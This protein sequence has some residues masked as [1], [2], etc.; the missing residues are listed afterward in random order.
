MSSGESTAWLT[1]P[2]GVT[3]I[4]I[5]LIL[6]FVALVTAGRDQ[7]ALVVFVIAGLTDTLDG[8]I[9]R[10]WGQSSKSGR[11][12]DPLAD[13]LLTA[14]SFITLSLFRSGLRVIPVWVMTAVVL[15]DLA[16]LGGSMIIY[17]VRR[18]S[19]FQPSI[20]GKLNTLIEIGVVVCFLASSMI[21]FIAGLLPYLYVL[22]LISLLISAAD[23]CRTGFRMLREPARA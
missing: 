13:K 2:N 7:E 1:I 18:N 11:L 3:A 16:I 6:P 12:L 9:A 20:F 5:L 4:R 22:L 10:R 19:G 17:R 23:Y 15:R 8:T 21:G 14:A